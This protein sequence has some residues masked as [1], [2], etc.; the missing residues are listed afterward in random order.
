MY[1]YWD[2]RSKKETERLHRMH[3]PQRGEVKDDLPS[4]NSDEED[5]DDREEWSSGIDS[6]DDYDDYDS[7]EPVPDSDSNDKDDDS[8]SHTNHRRKVKRLESDDEEMPYETAPRKPNVAWESDDEADKGIDRLPIK[9]A[10]GRVQKSGSKVFL[11]QDDETAGD[12][13]EEEDEAPLPEERYKVEDVSTGARFGRPAVADVILTKSR[14]VRI[15]AAK[16]QIA[17]I[18]QE[19]LADPENS[20]RDDYSG[21][22]PALT[23]VQNCSLDYYDGLTRS[24]YPRLQ[25]RPILVQFRTI[26]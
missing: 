11:T 26:R 18:C 5:E 8:S 19:I 24:R 21:T 6:S 12:E 22:L 10:D 9:L 15:Q 3:K 1:S 14:K 23:F 20:V 25:H 7:P 2:A 17:G 4:I 13:S 16:E